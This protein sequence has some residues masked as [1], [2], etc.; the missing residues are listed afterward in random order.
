MIMEGLCTDSDPT[1]LPKLNS[2]FCENVKPISEFEKINMRLDAFHFYLE[3]MVNNWGYT[4][5]G[6]MH[7]WVTQGIRYSY[8]LT[9]DDFD[10]WL[11]D[12]NL[13]FLL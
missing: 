2:V 12:H 3:D 13:S 8:E 11:V 4:P 5:W 10:S 9:Y 6:M 1:W 7:I